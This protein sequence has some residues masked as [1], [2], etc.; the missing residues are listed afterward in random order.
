MRRHLGQYAV[1]GFAVWL[2]SSGLARGGVVYVGDDSLGRFSGTVDVLSLRHPSTANPTEAGGVAWNGAADVVTG[3]AISGATHTFGALNS[4][5]IRGSRFALR[6]ALAEPGNDPTLTLNDF[7][8]NFFRPD[9]ALGFRLN[10]V[11]PPGGLVLGNSTGA[12]NYDHIF[13]VVFD[14]PTQAS[15]FNDPANA[16]WR[17]GL[18]V[19]APITNASGGA[20]D[21]AFARLDSLQAVPEPG[22]VTLWAVGVA[23]TGAWSLRRRFRRKQEHAA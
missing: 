1:L 23:G 20:E 14:N 11:A 2:S 15:L 8:V 19:T 3:D 9:G 6:F 7:E 5:G 12:S 13:R 4:A 10:Y 21:F 18:N 17:V 16:N 22:V